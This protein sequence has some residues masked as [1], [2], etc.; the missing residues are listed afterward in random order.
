MPYLPHFFQVCT[1]TNTLTSIHDC[2]YILCMKVQIMDVCRVCSEWWCW[3][4]SFCSR[5]V[6]GIKL[7]TVVLMCS[8]TVFAVWQTLIWLCST[9]WDSC[10]IWW[11]VIQTWCHYFM[12]GRKYNIQDAIVNTFPVYICWNYYHE[13]KRNDAVLNWQP[14]LIV[15]FNFTYVP[16][17]VVNYKN[18]SSH[19]CHSFACTEIIGMTSPWVT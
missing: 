9:Q 10:H 12:N 4:G 19:I 18:G 1:V 8:R 15:L 7:L 11:C 14:H 5:V 17:L 6:P 3:D 2:T 16:V 13:W